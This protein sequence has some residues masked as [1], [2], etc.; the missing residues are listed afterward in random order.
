MLALEMAE[1]LASVQ[2]GAGMARENLL[3][4]ADELRRLALENER[5]QA[6]CQQCVQLKN[7]ALT[8]VHDYAVSA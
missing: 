3:A 2:E 7:I 5:L 8:M 1:R 4:I 6:Q